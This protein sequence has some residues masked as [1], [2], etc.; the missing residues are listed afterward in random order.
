MHLYSGHIL[1]RN[2]SNFT[3][4]HLDFKNFS[5]K[6]PPDPCLQGGEKK[7]EWE[8]IRGFLPLKEGEGGKGRT[9]EG[10]EG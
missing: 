9:G 1:S 3:C 8:G 4:S 5:T 6:K 7:G 2:A 10:R